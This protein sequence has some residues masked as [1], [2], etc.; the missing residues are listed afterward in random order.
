MSLVPTAGRHLLAEYRGCPRALLDD[1][2][3]LE[4]CLRAAAAAAG[5]R[6]LQSVFHRFRPHGVSG[7]LV[8]EES[9]LSIHTWPEIGYAAVDFYTCGQGEPIRAHEVLE[10]GLRAASSEILLIQRGGASMR[11]DQVVHPSV[12]VGV[13][14]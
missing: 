13:K 14:E 2:V 3:D 11:V 8:I 1:A 12:D 4:A 10:R 7:I 6:V 5:V 9:H